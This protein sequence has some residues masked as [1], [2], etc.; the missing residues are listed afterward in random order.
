MSSLGLVAGVALAWFH[1]EHGENGSVA[2]GQPVSGASSSAK[3][4]EPQRVPGSAG[5]RAGAIDQSYEAALDFV[6]RSQNS[7]YDCGQNLR[8][9]SK[10]PL[11][12]S[13][14]K[15]QEFALS[16]FGL[17]TSKRKEMEKIV[18]DSIARTEEVVA[19]RIR[20]DPVACDPERGI[21][22]YDIPP[23]Q[24]MGREIMEQARQ[25]FIA[26]VGEEKTDAMGPLF[27]QIFSPGN[28]GLEGITLL[29]TQDAETGEK[30]IQFQTYD[31]MTRVANG[32]PF[33]LN[34]DRTGRFFEQLVSSR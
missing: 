21:V 19:T 26:L 3:G 22:A 6:R 11:T 20:L 4:T 10:G 34:K 29:V 5:S 23:D 30:T 33:P 1:A 27:M 32:G 8:V 25:G 18:G 2:K 13:D 31:P 17:P 7:S 15:I 9:A 12:N 16:L 24:K 14:G 28:F